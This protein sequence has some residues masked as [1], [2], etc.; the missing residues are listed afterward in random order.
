VALVIG[1]I[2]TIYGAR[3]VADAVRHALNHV[4]EVPKTK[5]AG[6]PKAQLKSMTLVIGGGLGFVGA[7]LLSGYATGALGHSYF[8]RA[9]PI[10]LSFVMLLIVFTFIFRIGSSANRAY[11]ELLPGAAIA[12]VGMQ[13]LQTFGGYLITH[14]LQHLNSAYSQFGLVLALLFWLYLQAQVF[15]YAAEINTVRSLKLYPRSIMSKPL[16]TADKKAY[17]LY[18]HREVRQTPPE[19]VSVKFKK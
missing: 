1:L 14:Q 12:A 8:F 10:F 17:E 9:L 2:I 5:R 18:A 13:I 4:W 3:G 11:H 6:F 16:T 19:E 15:L 7:A